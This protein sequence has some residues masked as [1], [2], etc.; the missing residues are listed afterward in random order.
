MMEW[1]GV[2]LTACW[3]LTMAMAPWLLLGF[4]MAGICSRMI[5]KEIIQKHIAGNNLTSVLKAVGLGIPLP[6][7]SCGVIPVAATLRNKGA[8]KGAVA[9]FTA[10]TPQT[11][12]DSIAATYSLMGWIFTLGRLCADIIAGILAGVLINLFAGDK[13]SI[14]ASKAQVEENKC[15]CCGGEGEMKA[16]LQLSRGWVVVL[17]EGFVKM[18]ADIGKYLV[19]GILLGALI[20]T[21]IPADL[22]DG[23]LGNP[24]WSYLII[25]LVAVPLYVCATGSIP[26]AFAMMQV[27][28]SPGAAIVFLVAGPAT[29]TATFVTLFKLIGR[30]ATIIYLFT[31]IVGAWSVGLIFDYVIPIEALKFTYQHHHE[32]TASWLDVC[33]AILLIVILANALLSWR[34]R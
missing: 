6:L 34:K 3:E 4:A 17:R 20:T 23:H 18:P 25:T 5:S 30:R 24:V 22:L 14:I 33:S 31:L 19:F 27:G 1:F 21:V 28:L 29:N 10:A 12:V 2:F 13:K 8:S 11:G 9:A 32:A 15:C 26:L 7:C 16:N